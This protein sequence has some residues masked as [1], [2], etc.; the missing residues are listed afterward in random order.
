MLKSTNAKVAWKQVCSFKSEGGLGIRDVKGVNKVYELKLIWRMLTGESLWGKWIR[1]NLL[2]GKK[3]WTLSS[4]TQS[5]SW[6]W[7][8]MLKLIEVAKL[9]YK[10]ELGNRRHTSF[11]LINGQIGECSLTY[12]VKEAL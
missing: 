6:M 9:F 7:H 8:K 2:K 11:G 4:K 12:W 10:K 3:F 5:G 1:F